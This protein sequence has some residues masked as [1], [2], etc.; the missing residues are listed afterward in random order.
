[1]IPIAASGGPPLA[2]PWP[3]ACR[4]RSLAKPAHRWRGRRRRA[5]AEAADAG[6]S[7]SY[8]AARHAGGQRDAAAAD[9]LPR[10][11]AGRSAQQRAARP[12]LPAGAANGEVDEAVKLA[13]RVCRSTRTIASRGSCSACARSSRS[14][15]GVRAEHLANRSAADHRSRRHA[16][17]GLDAGGADRG[18]AGDR[19]HRQARRRRLVCDLQGSACRPDPR[20]RRPEEGGR[21][22]LRARLQARS[23]RAARGR[24]P[25][26]AACRAS[27]RKDE[28][29]KVFA[30]FDK[31]CRAIR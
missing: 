8:L 20:P 12:R 1:M 13:E 23:D 29:L 14:N 4:R 26:A 11:A 2:V 27:S 7:G 31:R 5:I 16:A 21:Q 28:A 17:V 19:R 30:A 10:R 22:A 3:A 15:T 6:P 24:R 9:L 25:M 18:Q